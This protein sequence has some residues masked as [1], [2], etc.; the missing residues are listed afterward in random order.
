MSAVT[1]PRS[2]TGS[3]PLPWLKP[4][5]W[6]GGLSPLA[7][8]A[9]DAWAGALGAHPLERLLLQTGLLALLTLILSLLCTPLRQWTGWTWPAR[10]RRELGLLAFGYA[11]AHLLLYLL[12]QGGL[13]G[14]PADI[15]ERPFITVGLLAL[16]LLLPAA[17]TSG[18][19]SVRRL[20]FARWQR[21]H[22]LV[23]PAAALGA[24]HF[25]WGVKGDKAEP[26]LY[27]GALAVLLG[28]R[29]WRSRF[30]GRRV[31]RDSK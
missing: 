24:L 19:G 12:D 22:R 1:P 21:L 14:L 9:L 20:G 16:A 4:A 6:L 3:G 10:I 29:V 2:A 28:W 17:L 5:V 25:Y 23:Y 18:K 31:K 30:G 7:V 13:G 27:A 15:A 26:L 8:M 11:C